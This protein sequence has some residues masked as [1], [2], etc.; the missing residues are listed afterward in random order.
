[1]TYGYC[2]TCK[3]SKQLIHLDFIAMLF[4][5]I[6]QFLLVLDAQCIYIFL[7]QFLLTL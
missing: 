3:L 2:E 5:L 4:L 1:M 7:V 6:G